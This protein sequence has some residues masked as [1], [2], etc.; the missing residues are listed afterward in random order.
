MSNIGPTVIRHYPTPFL[1]PAGLERFIPSLGL[2]VEPTRR[3]SVLSATGA[4][5][6]PVITLPNLGSAGGSLGVL[7]AD[8]PPLL[9]TRNGVPAIKTNGAN[10]ARMFDAPLETAIG[11]APVT[12]Y[13]VATIAIPATGG[14]FV[15]WGPTT[16]AGI[17]I[18]PAGV[19]TAY[20][21]SEFSSGQTVPAGQ[22]RVM[23]FVANGAS[24]VLRINDTE[25]NGTTGTT[26][27]APY[28]F[29]MGGNT[30]ADVAEIGQFD[31]ALT[32]AERDT[33]VANLREQYGI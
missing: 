17:K 26:S 31:R 18:T 9:G 25:V 5:G 1:N 15:G 33:L 12:I 11:T 14:T 19:L 27:I 28:A 29:G 2:P 4:D 23:V 10:S 13:A 24:S 21:G 8:T 7:A 22:W 30:P 32:K 20:R 3:Y 16:N 6:S